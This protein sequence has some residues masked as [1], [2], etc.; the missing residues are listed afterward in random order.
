MRSLRSILSQFTVRQA[1]LA[2]T[3]QN[4]ASLLIE[5]GQEVA[6]GLFERVDLDT[7]LQRSADSIERRF[8]AVDHVQIYVT[9]SDGQQATLRAA[10]GPAGQRLLEREYE[11]DTGGLSAVGRVT[12]TR[13]PLLI[14]DF[15]QEKIHRPL[16]LLSDMRTE[17]AIPLVVQNRVIGALDVQSTRPN[18]FSQ[19]AITLL[20]AIADQLTI[21]VDS[22]QLYEEAQRNIR[23]N[24]ALFEQTQANL[25]EIERLNY[26]LT[27]RAWNEYLRLQSD[28]LH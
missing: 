25:R 27:G 26:Q 12:L 9:R 2:A 23:E 8:P 16:P 5:M 10:T 21:A 1:P 20:Y 24:Q 4:E 28:R 6:Q 15:Q 13:R 7:F 19:V 3:P 11:L 17:L 22:L 18:A 14:A